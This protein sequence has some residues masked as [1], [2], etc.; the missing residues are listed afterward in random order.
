MINI[1]EIEDHHSLAG[2]E[3]RDN[4]RLLY[5]AADMVT[6]LPACLAWIKEARGALEIAK[7]AVPCGSEIASEIERLLEEAEF[8]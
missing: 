2:I 7:I 3:L 5:S 6:D 4:G 8:D 1:K